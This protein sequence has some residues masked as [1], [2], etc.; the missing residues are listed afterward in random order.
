VSIA[1]VKGR[2]GLALEEAPSQT[3]NGVVVGE[4]L[5]SSSS[6]SSSTSVLTELRRRAGELFQLGLWLIKRTF[7]PSLIR[8][9]RKHGFLHRSSTK[10]GIAILRR[11]AKK[12]RR[13]LCA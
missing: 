2:S 7:Q 1:V 5:G 10:D 6:S 12:G 4:G 8:R 3:I 13:K 9:K 11:R